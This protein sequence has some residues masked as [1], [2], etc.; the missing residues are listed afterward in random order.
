MAFIKSLE[1]IYFLKNVDI[2]EYYFG[3]KVE[4]IG[5]SWKN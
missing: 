2:P 5:D 3:G 1:K 4:L